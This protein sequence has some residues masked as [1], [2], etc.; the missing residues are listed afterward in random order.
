MTV[1][2]G[3]G[4]P[5]NGVVIRLPPNDGNWAPGTTPSGAHVDFEVAFP[6]V[7][8]CLKLLMEETPQLDTGSPA[9]AGARTRPIGGDA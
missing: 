8:A 9:S 3:T 5:H 2:A 1:L 4:L 6:P 7:T